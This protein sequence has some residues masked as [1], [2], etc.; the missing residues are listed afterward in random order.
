MKHSLIITSFLLFSYFSITAQ[1]P[2]SDFEIWEPDII[3]EKPLGWT[4]N[5][6]KFGGTGVTQ[7]TSAYTGNYA[8]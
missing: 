6:G 1:I 4:T 2:N 5:N 7:D 3:Y 8:I